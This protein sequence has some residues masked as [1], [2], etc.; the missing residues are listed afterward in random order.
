MSE[1]FEKVNPKNDQYQYGKVKV[2]LMTPQCTRS[3]V[4]NPI[5]FMLNE[6]DKESFSVLKEFSHGQLHK[7]AVEAGL[8]HVESLKA[9]MRCE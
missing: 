6:G 4:A 2:I 5:E 1:Q 9:A 7:K 8:Q 3:A